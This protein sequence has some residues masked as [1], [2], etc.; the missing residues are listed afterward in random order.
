MTRYGIIDV[1]SNTIRTVVYEVEGRNYKELINEKD[2]SGIIS[3]V[4]DGTLS[5]DGREKLIQVLTDMSTLCRLLGCKQTHCFATASLRNVEN[6]DTLLGKIQEQA[7]LQVHL[8]SGEQEAAYDYAGLRSAVETHDG[9]GLDLGGGSCQI[10]H[11]QND[12]VIHAVSLPIGCLRTHNE[13]VKGIMP[14]A[15]ETK[16]IRGYVLEQLKTVPELR[17]LGYDTLYGMGGTARAGA[18][19][20]KAFVGKD[21]G[22][23]LTLEQ[24]DDLCNLVND[25]ELNGVR[26]IGQVLPERVTTI[27]PGLLTLQTICKYV[28][29]QQMQ[30]VKAGVREGYLWENILNHS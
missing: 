17:K 12:A 11:Y 19:L 9:I 3:Y 13:F 22:G 6:I 20:H 18:K 14:T 8:I 26:L 21:K 4:K 16:A 7:N 5:E 29:A 1:G 15:K 30:V 2:F 24:I 23:L 28:G 27:L 10:F 25:L